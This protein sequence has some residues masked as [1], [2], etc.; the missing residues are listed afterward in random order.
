[1]K[2]PADKKTRTQALILAALLL[3]AA[4]WGVVIGVV[5]PLRRAARLRTGRIE[6]LRADIRT[7]ERRVG[8]IASDETANSNLLERIK[9]EDA[10]VL[11]SRL[12]NYLLSATEELDV[13]AREAAVDIDAITEVGVSVR[14]EKKDQAVVRA[15]NMY[16]AN[17]KLRAGLHDLVRLLETATAANPYLTVTGI[18]I[19]ARAATPG[20]HEISVALQWPIWND[21]E[22]APELARTLSVP[23]AI[24]DDDSLPV[25]SLLDEPAPEPEEEEP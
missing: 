23:P 11:H 1:M 9:A 24:P 2:L 16:T 5:A 13:H 8:L 3:T 21:A 14:P 25:P 10:Y 12:G 22:G 19:D 20:R 17:V 6:T 7:A 18:E 4:I 15:L